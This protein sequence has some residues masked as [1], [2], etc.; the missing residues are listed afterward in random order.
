MPPIT[1][2]CND[3]GVEAP[4]ALQEAINL[5]Q[6]WG[7]TELRPS[8][9]ILI[10]PSVLSRCAEIKQNSSYNILNTLGEILI[11]KKTF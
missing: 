10:S 4:E 8:K 7:K 1:I 2:N 11:K 6:V 9:D 3:Q 5:F